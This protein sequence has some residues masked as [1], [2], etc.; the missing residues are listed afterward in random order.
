MGG[1]IGRL[2]CVAFVSPYN[3]LFSAK[4]EDD[5]KNGQESVESGSPHLKWSR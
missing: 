4:A 3:L 1:L 5:K 2:R